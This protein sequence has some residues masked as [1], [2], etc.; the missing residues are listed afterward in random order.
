MSAGQLVPLPR[1]INRLGAVNHEAD[2]ID[3]GENVKH[4]VVI[5]DAGRPNAP[6]VNIP[7]FEAK[8]RPK[9][10]PVRAITDELDRKSVV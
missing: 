8:G 10:E 2:A 1:T 9:I 7:A 6:T 5:A 4:A 3:V